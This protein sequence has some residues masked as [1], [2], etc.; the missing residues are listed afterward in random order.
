MGV[1]VLAENYIIGPASILYR[2]VAATG[3][4]TDLGATLDDAVMRIVSEWFVPDNITGLKAPVVGLDV[5]RRLNAEFEFTLPDFVGGNMEVVFP[6][7]RVTAAVFNDTVSTPFTSTIA[8]ADVEAGAQSIEVLAVTNLAVG[9]YIRIGSG[10]GVLVEYRQ[11]TN[12]AANVI[13]FRDPLLFPHAIGE[14]AVE[15]DGDYRSVYE[16][17]LYSRMPTSAYKEWAMRMSNGNGYSELRLPRGLSTTETAEVTVGDNSLSG[18]R[19]MV[20][21]RGDG[22]NPNT[23]P[24]QL[25][26]NESPGPA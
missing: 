22:P 17:S 8:V 23:S 1:T 14:D 6:G 5:Q 24:Y 16:A 3:D 12:I 9:D 10:A 19:V 20:S 7:A 18:I 26:I 15:T 2:D 4:W 11:V 13:S 25:I 21:G